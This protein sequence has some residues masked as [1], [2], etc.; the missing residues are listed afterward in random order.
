MSGTS[1]G[2]AGATVLLHKLDSPSIPDQSVTTG[3][4]GVYL[5]QNL[6]SGEYQLTE[7]PPA[8]YVNDT[9]PVQTA[10]PLTP[11]SNPNTSS[12][13]VDVLLGDP[14]Q[15]LISYPSHNKEEL[16]VNNNGL[17]HDSL[18]GQLNITVT[19]TDTNYTSP[20]FPSFCVDFYRDINTGDTSRPYSMTPLDQALSADTNV[21]NPQNISAIAY[22]Y[23]T[24]GATWSTNPSQ[25][26]PTAE[27][28]GLQLAIWELEYE[29][30][31]APY[32]VLTGS[33]Y[34]H[35]L[36]ASSPEVQYAQ[37][38]LTQAATYMSQSSG[39]ENE[40]ALYLSGLP[41]SS[42]PAG[43]QGLIA[44]E[45]LNFANQPN[46]NP[47]LPATLSGVVYVDTNNN[48]QYDSGTDTPLAGVVMTLTGTDTGGNT[49]HLTTTTLANGTYTFSGVPVSNAAGYTLTEAPTP[50]YGEGTN[51][52]GTP[53][54][55]TVSGDTISA[56]SVAS[57]AVL[58]NYNFGEVAGSLTG[59]VY[60]DINNNGQYDSGTDTPVSG[61]VMT[62]TGTDV[63]GHSVDQTTTTAANGTYDFTGLVA[64]NAAG[65][66]V[67]RA[68]PVSPYVLATD[69]P[70]VPANGTVLGDGISSI[71]VVGGGN[72]VSYNFGQI[73]RTQPALPITLGGTVFVESDND[74]I[75]Q[76]GEAGVAG[77]TITLSGFDN[78]GQTVNMVT[79]TNSQGQYTFNVAKPGTYVVTEGATPGYIQGKDTPGTAGGTVFGNSI[80]GIVLTAGLSATGYNFALLHPGSLSGYVYYDENQNGVMDAPDYGIAHV[81][82]TLEGTNDL[83]QSV[84]MTTVTNDDGFYSFGGLRPGTYEIIRTHPAIF[85]DYQ[86]NVGSLGGIAGKDSISGISLPACGQGINYDFG[87]LQTK[88]CNLRNLALSVGNLFY[89]FERSYQASPM[90]I[91]KHYPKL[92]PYLAAGRVPF[93]IA[94]FPKA[95]LASYWVPELGTKPIKVYPV[96]GV[97]PAAHPQGPP[98]A[99]VKPARL[100]K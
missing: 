35:N 99:R 25:Y 79:T 76:T 84:Q 4:S 58:T 19:E 68:A 40:L 7:T 91:A 48:G 57:G 96:K 15:L 39:S 46:L 59:V 32:D 16:V 38:F 47:S 83:A 60:V 72:L 24:Y 23:N 28:V 85:I 93:G 69:T 30:N 71:S 49:V 45:S 54:N 33:S 62:L 22:L 11:I 97:S 36:D 18:V 56:I 77:I 44:P 52:P 14:S 98:K 64:S 20:L 92:V 66:T 21:T 9:L 88:T 53:V 51:T 8:G 31:P 6:P 70:G 37:S 89:H 75:Q 29:Q 94:P 2:L 100:H 81:T 86:N 3:A 63:S 27:A 73:V 26:V 90:T 80:T 42:V 43:Y 61:V 78:T 12:N 50:A 13:S 41:T 10:S 34:V 1:Q 17:T 55:G 82:V 65:Y 87:E 74:G 5:F 95:A 67:T